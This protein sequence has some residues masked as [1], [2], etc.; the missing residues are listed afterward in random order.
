MNI[1]INGATLTPI[2][3]KSINIFSLLSGTPN[4]NVALTH[5]V[6]DE[7]RG[8]LYYN[9]QCN[10]WIFC[11]LNQISPK[12]FSKMVLLLESPHK[13]EFSA[14]GHPLRPANGKTGKKI[15][16]L[17]GKIVSNNSPKSLNNGTIYKVYL[18][19]AIQYQTSCYLGLHVYP[20]YSKNW[21]TIRNS[22]F[23]CLWNDNNLGLQKDLCT[24]IKMINP[25]IIMNCVT[26][27]NNPKGLR[28][29]VEQLVHSNNLYNHPSSW[30]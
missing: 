10:T 15:N 5:A 14:S 29:M 9:R 20:W 21:R 16:Q 2:F 7:A 11:G 3:S 24:R 17:L 18:V 4:L 30:H 6:A 26:G 25:S 28:A 8:Y 12:N 23:K 13:D 27:G 22:V 1:Q 19:N